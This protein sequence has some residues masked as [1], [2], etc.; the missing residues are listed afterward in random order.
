M[1]DTEIR[2]LTEKLVNINSVNG[3]EGEVK[4]AEFI[5][6]YLRNLPYYKEHPENIIIQNIPGDALGRKSVIALLF[7]EKDDNPS[8]VLLHGH[9]DTVGIDDYGPLRECACFPGKLSEELKKISLPDDVKADLLSGNYMF[10]RGAA[11]MKS[12][13]AVFL[14]LLRRL[15]EHPEELSGNIAASFNPVEENLHTGMITSLPVFDRL[16]REG[17]KFRAALNNDFT[18]ALY[19][20][21]EEV[22]LYTG[23]G[24][25]VLP[26][27]Y[28]RG[29]ETHT[30]Q[31]FEGFDAAETAAALVREFQRNCRYA[32]SAL[33]EMAPPPSV[34]KLKDL[35]D[36]YNVQTA[37]EA[38]CYFN[39]YIFDSDMRPVTEK[40]VTGARKAFAEVVGKGNAENEIYSRENNF[41]VR[42]HDFNV[43]VLTYAEL[44]DKAKKSTGFDASE[45]D[46]ILKS[47]RGKGTDIREIPVSMIRYLLAK[48]DITEPVI[49]LYYAPPYV[50]HCRLRYGEQFCPSD[51]KVYNALNKCAGEIAESE[52]VRF[53]IR[54]FYPSLSDS[55]FI[56]CDDGHESIETLTE[57]FPGF[58]MLSPVPVNEIK[59]VNILPLNI[60]V[61]GKDAHKW[62][63]RVNMPY[64]FGVLPKLEMKLIHELLSI[65]DEK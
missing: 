33:G 16:K 17:F 35:K 1:I 5:E 7:G 4:I 9:I 43:N 55:S 53:R 3:T 50:P 26:C 23:M 57:N 29:H 48:A 42:D 28:I 32:D 41:P 64:T 24:G 8:T 65:T 2:E 37:K 22:T 13:D 40:L 20:G 30:G 54:H 46:R 18:T 12:G 61:L 11:D 21:D 59:R 34:L 45:L 14:V 38:L 49:V 63:E 62:T 36:S 44:L 47:E 25:K 60:G 56:M 51:V 39:Y 19:P 31:C 6:D 15:S 27:F 10:G 58:D 52:N